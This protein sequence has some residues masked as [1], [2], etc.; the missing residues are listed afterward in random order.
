VKING[1]LTKILKVKYTNEGTGGFTN[2]TFNGPIPTI[3][4]G[5]LANEYEFFQLHS[6]WPAEHTIKGKQFNTE[7]HLVHYNK[8]K[9]GTFAAAAS[10][11]D[12][13][14][15]LGILFYV[16]NR[17]N[18]K[19]PRL[20]FRMAEKAQSFGDEYEE[21]ISMTFLDIIGA[22]VFRIFT[23]SGSLTTPSKQNKTFESKMNA[24]FFKHATKR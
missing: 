1:I 19:A 12:G 4:G 13:L 16:N 21:N 3:S 11:A 15:V 20:I 10:K 7:L 2:F 6:H 14:A 18:I 24:T 23:Y 17:V 8:K 5:P 9:Y 22:E